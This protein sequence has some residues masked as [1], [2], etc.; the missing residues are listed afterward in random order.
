MPQEK[1]ARP[2]EPEESSRPSLKEDT[3]NIH[4]EVRRLEVYV[5]EEVSGVSER[6]PRVDVAKVCLYFSSFHEVQ[7]A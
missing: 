4:G 6:A 7:S 5:A 1:A 3:H 2:E